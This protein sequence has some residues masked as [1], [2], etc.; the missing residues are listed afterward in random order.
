M[1]RGGSKEMQAAGKWVI[2]QICL[3]KNQN[4]PSHAKGLARQTGKKEVTPVFYGVLEM[5]CLCGGN[6][7]MCNCW[8]QSHLS[9]LS[10]GAWL[11]FFYVSASRLITLAVHPGCSRYSLCLL[12]MHCEIKL[13]RGHLQC[14][15]NFYLLVSCHNLMGGLVTWL[16]V[17]RNRC[18]WTGAQWVRGQILSTCSWLAGTQD[19]SF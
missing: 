9:A 5:K 2:A 13:F 7:K 4:S 3:L 15:C 8:P 16:K 1:G 11:P 18:L 10:A 19:A 14:R 17:R 6:V 12:A